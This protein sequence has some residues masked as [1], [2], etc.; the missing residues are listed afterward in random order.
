MDPEADHDSHRGSIDTSLLRQSLGI[1]DA[2]TSADQVALKRP[3]QPEDVAHLVNWLLSRESS[4][5][6]G[7]IQAIDGGWVC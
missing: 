3:G 7:S 1:S 4:Y 2:P 5:I 6:T